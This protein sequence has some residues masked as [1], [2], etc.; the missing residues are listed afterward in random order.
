MMRDVPALRAALAD[1]V[2]QGTACG[3]CCWK[4]HSLVALASGGSGSM[5][6]AAIMAQAV[7]TH[8]A[9]IATHNHRL[10]V[11]FPEAPA[12][13]CALTFDR[14]SATPALKPRNNRWSRAVA[15]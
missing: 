7:E 13:S 4:M 9:L 6:V 1:L 3:S 8:R 14:G 5:A 11:S 2:A 15:K 10:S 12:A